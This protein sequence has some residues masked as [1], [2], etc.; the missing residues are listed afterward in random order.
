MAHKHPESASIAPVPLELADHVASRIQAW[1]SASGQHD[2]SDVIP[3]MARVFACSDFVAAHC[4]REP[5]FIDEL[6]RTQGV[7]ETANATL[8]DPPE[9]EI[10]FMRA[11]RRLRNQEMARIAW[12]DLCG[13]NTL[14]ETFADLSRLADSCI[15]AALK[16]SQDAVEKKHGVLLDSA[17]QPQSLVVVAMGKLGG[18]ELNFSSDIDLVMLYPEAGES[19]GALPLSSDRYFARIGQGLIK[20]LDQIT[21]DGFVFRVDSRLRPF[22]TTGALALSF[23]AFE[24]YLQQHGREW[25]RYAYVK[26]RP[27]TGREADRQQFLDLV[28]PFVYRRYLDYG[29]LESL[30]EMKALIAS[31]VGRRERRDDIKLGPGGIREVEF[32]TQTF[33]LLRGGTDPVLREPSLRVALRYLAQRRSLAADAADQ[34][35]RAYEFL[36]RVENRLQFWRDEQT[37]HLPEDAVGQSRIA[38]SMGY[39]D[40]AGF[41]VELNRHRHRVSHHFESAILGPRVDQ[42]DVLRA[43]W[44]ADPGSDAA[45]TELAGLGFDVTSGVQKQLKVLRD[46]A[47]YRHLDSRGRQRLDLLIPR[48]LRLAATQENADEVV[49]RLLNIVVAMGRRSAY[50]ALLTENPPVLK[51]LIHLSAISPWLARR[52]AQHPILLDELIDPRVFEIP[53]TRADFVADMSQR[54]SVIA[55][56][57]LESEMEALRMF[58]QAAVFRVAVSDLSGVLPLMKVSDRLTE[59][60]EL[61]LEKTIELA[62][63]EMYRRHGAPQCGEEND[64]RIASF[65]VVGYGKLGGLELGYASDLDLVLLHDSAGG[66]QH[67]DGEK[68]LDNTRYFAR[69]GQRILHILSTTTAAGVLYQVDTRLRPSGKG[70]PMVSSIAAFENYQRESAWTWEHQALLRARAVAGDHVVREAFETARCDLL[71]RRRDPQTLR[72]EVLAM[73]Q[74]MR[75]ELPGGD[76]G[77]FD[78]KQDSGGLTDIEFMVQYWVLA[79]A[80]VHPTLVRWSD[81]IRQ[82]ESLVAAGVVQAETAQELTDIYRGYRQRVHRL[83]LADKAAVVPEEEFI[84]ERA[85]VS[86][87]WRDVFG[88]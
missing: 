34:L 63:G 52:V 13:Q 6:N 24:I 22:G 27:L 85:R 21:E 28:R 4:I 38:F 43:A 54:F 45:T 42:V 77:R 69:L 71:A 17:H 25:E 67:S 1:S 84:T 14:D 55:E 11:L 76:P 7:C 53:P 41:M 9:D 8:A 75:R 44:K 31:D 62:R 35:D 57:D 10:E 82:L 39:K 83:A 49:S 5:T 12:R 30:R 23:A 86:S 32:I 65:A 50:F 2:A 40:W 58:Q 87:G 59:I 15:V 68:S 61:V 79:N 60:A 36:R 88:E 64:L 20:V 46:S 80:A 48:I 81:N 33:Q 18:S 51:R 3:G 72:E 66:L 56:D 70:G 29:V 19:D 47:Q 78:I 74:R 26:A 16:W 73:R 37:H